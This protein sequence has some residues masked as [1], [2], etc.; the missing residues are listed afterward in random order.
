MYRRLFERDNNT[1]ANPKGFSAGS[2]PLI[3]SGGVG[4]AEPNVARKVLYA[5]RNRIATGQG[6]KGGWKPTP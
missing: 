3:K 2:I 6:G 5:A 1:R 4:T